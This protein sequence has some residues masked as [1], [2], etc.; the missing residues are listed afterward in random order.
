MARIDESPPR[1]MLFSIFPDKVTAIQ[2]YHALQSWS[3]DNSRAELETVALLVKNNE[4]QFDIECLCTPYERRGAGP[5]C[6]IANLDDLKPLYGKFALAMCKGEVLLVVV[7][8]APQLGPVSAQLLS[9]SGQRL[10]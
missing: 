6:P 1:Q 3:C 5:T 4:G 10:S 7:F 2:T 8:P 9:L